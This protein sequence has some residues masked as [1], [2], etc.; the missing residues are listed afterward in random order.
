MPTFTILPHAWVKENYRLK[1]ALRSLFMGL[2]LMFFT[3]SSWGNTNE[4]G[5]GE[6]GFFTG[7]PTVSPSKIVGVNP[8]IDATIVTEVANQLSVKIRPTINVV[9]GA[10]SGGVVTVK[11]PTGVALTVL[12]SPYG[13]AQSAFFSN[14]GGLGFDYYIYLSD[15]GSPYTVTWNAGTAYEIFNL[16]VC[17]DAAS[18]TVELLFTN[19]LT[20]GDYY[21]ELNT[22]IANNAIYGAAATAD[23]TVTNTNTLEE[24]CTIQ[25]AIDDAQ[26]LDGHNIT[27]AAGTRYE[28]NVTV[29]KSV[30]I[31]GANFGVNGNSP[32]DITLAN[33]AR[34]SETILV[35][36]TFQVSDIN[37]KIDGFQ[38]NSA[39]GINTN[40]VL[41]NAANGLSITNNVFS[42]LTT[43]AY[44][45]HNGAAAQSNITFSTNRVDGNNT[46]AISAINAWDGINNVTIN[47]NYFTQFERGVQFDNASNVTVSNNHFTAI[48][49][50]GLQ[51]ATL[52]SNINVLSNTFDNC[53]T[54]ADPDQGAIR[55]YAGVTGDIVIEKNIFKNNHNAVRVRSADPYTHTFFKVRYN[56]FESSNTNSLSDGS[57][58]PTGKTNGLCNW[59]GVINGPTI[60]T[61]P[62]GAGEV[63]VDPNGQVNYRNWLMYG[64]DQDAILP[65]FQIPTA[66]TVVPGTNTSVAE[67]HYRV[68][69]NAVGCALAGQVITLN[70]TFDWT[71]A[72]AQAEWAK[73]NDGI[74]SA[75]DDY[76]ILAP[77][78]VNNVTLTASPQ[79]SGVVQGPGDLAA[80]NLEAV[81][82][83]DGGDNQSWIVEN[84]EI[85]DIDLAIYFGNGAGGVDAFN[86]VK[87]RNNK[88]W[89][90]KDLLA[91]VSQNIGLHYSFGTNQEI[92]GNIFEVD[93]TGVSAAPNYSASV[94]MQSNT[95]GATAYDG[96]QIKNNTININGAQNADPSIILGIWENGHN[97]NSA[98]TISGNIF[99]N[100]AVGNNPTLNLQRAFRVTSKS[101]GTKQVI[102]ENNE[103][104]GANIGIQWIDPY[105][106]PGGSMPVIVRNNKFDKT[107]DGI[108]VRQDGSSA[109]IHENSFTNTVRYAINNIAGVGTTN[110]TCNWFGTV[111]SGAIAALTSGAVTYSPYLILGTDDAPA[112]TG[113]QTSATCTTVTALY[114]DDTDNTGDVYTP[115]GTGSNANPGTAAL[116]YRTIQHAISSAGANDIIWVDAGGYP[117]N[118]IV[119][120]TLTIK[121]PKELV[122]GCDPLRGTGEAVVV[123]ATAAISSGE[124]FHVAASNV[125]IKGFTIDGDNTSIL[126]G[127]S[128]TNGADIDAAE[129]VTVYET[130]INNLT[131]QNN[132]FKNLSYFGVTLYDYPAGVP[133]SGH[134]ISDNKF[135]DFGTYDVGSTIERWGG[136]VL[137][138]NNQYASVVNNCMDNLR[139]GVQTG[140]FSLA[141]PGLPVS[142]V[143][144]GNQMT[145]IRRMGIFHNLHY[146]TASGLTLSNNTISG[147]TTTPDE[148]KWNGILLSSLSV[149]STTSGNTIDAMLVAAGQSPSGIEVWNVK[150]T[151]PSAIS[152]GSVTGAINGVFVNNYDGYA[153]DATDGAH[154]SLSSISISPAATGTGI[155][156]YDNPASTHANVQL[157]IGTG[158]TITA[159]TKGLLIENASASIVGAT[160][161]NLTFTGTTGNYIELVNNS[162]NLNGLTALFD[163]KTGATAT[164]TENFT[165]EDKI[166]HKID[167]GALGFVSV[168][169]NEDFVTPASF[170]PV[171]LTPKV[172]RGVNA[173]SAGY[174]VNVANGTY[175]EDLDINKSLT[176]DGES[177]AAILRG[178]NVAGNSVTIS[179]INATL[180]DVKV[181]RDFGATLASWY[182]CLK[183]QGVTINQS[184]TG[185]TLDNVWIT[186]NRNGLYINNA[187]S[188]TI[189]NCTIEDNRTGIQLVNNVS[190]GQIVNNFI[191][192]NFTLGVLY[193]VF[194]GTNFI[195]T[196]FKLNN[197]DIS[198]NWY[199]QVSFHDNGTGGTIGDLT[200]FDNNCNW[201]GTVTPDY[202][203]IPAGEPGYATQVPSQF[204]GLDPGLSADIRGTKANLIT[205]IPFTTNGADITPLVP[206]F[207]PTPGSC[208]G[209]GLVV[210]VTKNLTYPTIQLA[211]NDANPS[212][213]LITVPAGTFSEN[214]NITKPLTLQGVNYLLAGCSLSR[215]AE[216]IIAGGGGTA[217]TISANGVTL[218]GFQLDGRT[219]VSSTGFTD[220]IIK[221]NKANVQV[222][223]IT[224]SVLTTSVTDEYT[225]QDNCVDLLCQAYEAFPFDVSPTLSATPAAG[226][227]YV[228]RYAPAG[229][230]SASFGGGNRLKH[231]INIADTQ[232][233]PFYN[234]QGR[235]YDIAGTKA[236]SIQLYVPTAWG[237]Q[238]R[239]M[240]GFWGVGVDVSNVVSDYPIIEFSS[241]GGVPR[242]RGWN[243]A[244]TGSW[245]DMGLPTG[246]AYDQWYTLNIALVGNNFIYSV[247]DLELVIPADPTTVSMKS[248]I[249]QGYN[250]APG[251]TY[252]IYWDNLN[253]FCS[254]SATANTPTIG[255]LL[256]A[257][258]GTAAVTVQDNSVRDAFYA[259]VLSAVTTTPR[260][261]IKGGTYT[262]LV[263]GVAAV[264]TLNGV[265][266]APSTVGVENLTFNDFAGDYPAIPAANFHAGIY[267]FTG[268]SN[269]THTVDILVNN[270]TLKNTGK[271]APNS[272][273]LY[274]ADFSTGAGNRLNATVTLSTIQDNKNRGVEV[275][276]ANATASVSTSHILGNGVDPF[277]TGGNHGYGVY[278]GVGSTVTLLN[279]FIANPAVQISDNVTAL[280]EGVAPAATII[281]HDNSIVRNSNGLLA[282]TTSGTINGTNGSTTCNWW[283][284]SNPNVFDEFILGAVTYDPYL[285][286]GVDVDANPAN[287]FQPD[288]PCQDLTDFYVNDNSLTGDLITFAVG[289]DA[290]L[291]RGT[292]HRP[293]RHINAAIGAAANGNTIRVDIGTY[294]DEQVLVNKDLTIL[295][296]T[297]SPAA[298]PLINFTG[299]VTGKPTLMDVSVDG[300]TIDNIGFNVDLAKLRSAIIASGAAIDNI[301]VVN[302]V[303]DA[304]GTPAGSYGDRNAVSINYGGPTNYRVA[305]GGVNSITFTGNTVNGTLPTSFFRSGVAIDEGGGTLSGNTLQ[306]INHDVLVRFGSNGAVNITGNNLNGGGMEL[307]DQ[308]AA[309]GVFTVSGN[310]FTGV[311]APSTAM[312]RVK[313]NYNSISH[314]ISGNTFTNYEWGVSL[315]NMNTVTLDGNIF[316]TSSA[317]AHAVVVNT[318]SISGNSNSIL[319]VAVG[320]TMKNNMFNGTGTGLSFL[321]H[322]SDNDSYGTFT[323][324]TVGNANK[325]ASSL[326][327]FILLDNQTGPSN[328]STFPDYNAL[329][330]VG[331]SAITTMACW[332]EDI[333]IENNTFDVG[334]GQQLPINMINPQRATLESKLTHKPDFSCLGLLTYF[335]SLVVNAKVFL[336]GPY[337]TTSNTMNDDLR[338]IVM[339]PL[340]PLTTPYDTMPDFSTLKENNFVVETIT[341]GVRDNADV[342]NAIVDWVWVE[343]RNSLDESDIVATRSAL[344]QR[345]GDIVDMDG[346][347]KVKFPDTY[348]GNY[349]LMIRHRNHLGAMTN[350]TV[351]LNNISAL[352]DFSDPALV[353]D[354]TTGTSAR[355]L[356]E[357][358]PD[359]YGL[360]AGNVNQK[361]TEDNWRIKY[362]GTQ[363]DRN[364]ILK[365]VGTGTPLNIV[366]G[367]YHEDVNMNGQTRYTGA[368]ND[369][370]IILNNLGANNPLGT[371]TQQPNN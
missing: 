219:A 21:Q 356:L 296:T 71:N 11:C 194:G 257:A 199:A 227:W 255:V 280:Y 151:S 308:N 338:Q 3:T 29:T 58:S 213:D 19:G 10:Y 231:S 223:G 186:G 1:P 249:L 38:L 32:A 340:F 4:I 88:I 42:N 162:G 294:S 259:Y 170:T 256:A 226:A 371:I 7:T 123:P 196:S 224:S 359:I 318:K 369:R 236:M 121:G 49:I 349:F 275:R 124:I 43:T 110:A 117:E 12:S 200:G 13:Y 232:G 85:K 63:L 343:L 187:Q 154:A 72:T 74:V 93:G 262:N 360:W 37:V 353:T 16:G 44:S 34:V 203:A 358:S 97:L 326:T 181:T 174:I 218:I 142:Q 128:S 210:N 322:D 195:G 250:H 20:N 166:V 157:Q 109:E 25:Q 348:E 345:D 295:G 173:A 244:G 330:G 284:N 247:G 217:V 350:A 320:A 264:N 64:N 126:S 158:V 155:K 76:S 313:N 193:N 39:S 354:G 184:I 183:N 163:T 78:N 306:S 179:A 281:A 57:T 346:T 327:T 111:G 56:I 125:T 69:S 160:L 221:N 52:C 235:A 283:G 302:N 297:G 8:I 48:G 364:E 216:S 332:A 225:I 23:Y 148:T 180:K 9:A 101:G 329:I 334:A 204:A 95:D 26:T 191:R 51:V 197:N 94:V 146:S 248:V 149:P 355:K 100:L 312:L 234:T 127:F 171:T 189:Q 260:T 134:V 141:N 55:L 314:M 130:L 299:T 288:V 156:V 136:G 103:V 336:Q 66:I 228:D 79:Y 132:V 266:Y 319:Q 206:G 362:N 316:N 282:N 324:G 27:V 208:T 115:V 292:A 145:N 164:L 90:P 68:L 46:A 89:I 309:A 36:S 15:P 54:I 233:D 270:V 190:S 118:V 287:G 24:F 92:S 366:N 80:A 272:A 159:G 144:D 50:K 298:R 131:V 246:F 300:A 265:T 77:V 315:E 370:V 230:V 254:P 271:T 114:V 139:L 229:F 87:V 304:Y 342:N 263:Q 83:F 2:L 212:G 337:N 241:D 143:I 119:N 368:N 363:N 165:I 198:G 242:F 253:T 150:S 22:D 129:G 276:G 215:G 182:A 91:D 202:A 99:T 70:G 341:T 28:G 365:R 205:Y 286:S 147:K 104:D 351:T 105:T 274:L 335:Q 47:S 40:G 267:G 321:N 152:G 138:H 185:V 268:G 113:F 75:A 140:N 239:R 14:V 252:D 243:G 53:N 305:A 178:L 301:A 116:P 240:A 192:N 81:F 107:Y 98:I 357:T 347:S 31:K 61:N 303:I 120:K 273:G 41:A 261:T 279:N 86:N 211:I 238:G 331:A 352:V 175:N 82:V 323:I 207:Q 73:G 278:S 214:V 333:N 108:L 60:A 35:N 172:Q 269:A 201:Y 96:L 161:S 176:V 277:G 30:T 169:L 310:T 45:N 133:S 289:L 293:Y 33:G 112:T 122:D 361:D 220:I 339:G 177:L 65:G 135:Q 59:Y 251:L 290:P 237:T 188:F 62:G 168:K 245:V 106:Y 344:L 153:S 167:D 311:G 367:Y 137:L 6:K 222:F 325:F 307:S 17:A 102:Y 285:P 67:N 209:L 328:L 317:T 84:L 291:T 18:F 258:S 5:V